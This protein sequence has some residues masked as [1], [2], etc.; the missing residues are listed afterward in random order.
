MSSRVQAMFAS[1]SAASVPVRLDAEQ[2]RRVALRE[3]AAA[4][5]LVPHRAAERPDVDRAER[6]R[7][8][9]GVA[10]EQLGLG[11]ADVGEEDRLPVVAAP[12]RVL[13]DRRGSARSTNGIGP[14]RSAT[15]V[16]SSRSGLTA[17]SARRAGPDQQPASDEDRLAVPLGREGLLG[18]ARS[19]RGRRAISSSGAFAMTSRNTR[20]PSLAT[21]AG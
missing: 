10:V 9:R 15:G 6:R 3:R 12:V 13:R 20:S 14:L 19:S 11:V 2:E 18:A 5:G 21:S 4:L 8:G 17:S 7:P 16:A 1:S